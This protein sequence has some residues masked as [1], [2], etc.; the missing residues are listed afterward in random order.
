M[1]VR[2]GN[3]NEKTL[4]L[5]GERLIRHCSNCSKLKLPISQP[6]SANREKLQRKKTLCLQAERL[7]RRCS[8]CSKLKLPISQSFPADR[9]SHTAIA[10]LNILK[11][12]VYH[13]GCQGRKLQRK[14]FIFTR[15]KI[16]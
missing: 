15:T 6:F 10:N 9:E 1:D 16:D 14:N 4:F 11:W 3:F 8:N 13:H 2:E 5:Q 7:I 12:H